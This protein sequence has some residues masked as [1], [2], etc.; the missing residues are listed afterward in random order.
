MKRII[1]ILFVAAMF[2]S[3]EKEPDLDNVQDEVVTYTQYDTNASFSSYSSFYIADSIAIIGNK[4][5]GVMNSTMAANVINDVV[6]QLTSRGYTQVQDKDAADLG[7]QLSYVET[8]HVVDTG[9]PY[10]W[11]IFPGYWGPSYWGP[12]YG[13]WNY[14]YSN[15]F[16][17]YNGSLLCDL[18]DLT[19]D[20]DTTRDQALPVIWQSYSVGLISS[21]ETVNLQNMLTGINQAFT[22]SP[23][24]RR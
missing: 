1:P 21:S 24:I 3:C 6:A 23:Y 22:Q 8:R 15:R 17:Y 4:E 20:A 14:P 11:T 5:A 13:H 9:N 2:V 7:V 18:I 19:T 16:A 10:W 12:Y